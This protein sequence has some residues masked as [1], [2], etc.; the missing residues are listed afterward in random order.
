MPRLVYH[1]VVLELAKPV[2]YGGAVNTEL[3]RDVGLRE[4]LSRRLTCCDQSTKRML[5]QT[6][7]L[8]RPTQHTLQIASVH[9]PDVVLSPC[10]CPIIDDGRDSAVGLVSE[11]AAELIIILIVVISMGTII[12]AI[13]IIVAIV[14]III[15]AIIIISISIIVIMAII[16]IVDGW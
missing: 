8:S 14:A 13:I 16:I 2:T 15:M 4:S 10:G 7:V 12:V 11:S 9:V 3:L 6:I 1:I 5:V